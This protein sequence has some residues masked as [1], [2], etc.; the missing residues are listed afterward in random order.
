[1]IEAIRQ[2]RIHIEEFEAFD[3]HLRERFAGQVDEWGEDLDAWQRNHDLPCP[4][5]P[6]V[7]SECN[8]L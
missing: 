7:K 3:A 4:Y 2:A 6:N 8:S 1:M 5:L